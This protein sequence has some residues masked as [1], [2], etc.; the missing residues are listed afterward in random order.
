MIKHILRFYLKTT[1]ENMIKQILRSNNHSPIFLK[2][3]QWSCD[4]KTIFYFKKEK[5]IL[6]KF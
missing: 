1:L 3:N 4:L 5:T 6:K 2:S